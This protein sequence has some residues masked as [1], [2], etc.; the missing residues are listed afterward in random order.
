MQ[1]N[2]IAIV[3]TTGVGKSNLAIELAKRFNGEV[4]NADTLQVYK[5]LDI[6]TNKVTEAEKCSIPHHLMDFLDPSEEYT[7]KDFI[8]QATE[9]I[10]QIQS[11]NRIPILVGGTH[12]YVQSLLWHQS[13]ISEDT[14]EADNIKN[15]VPHS[16]ISEELAN[17]IITLLDKSDPAKFSF[18]N[19]EEKIVLSKEM[20]KIL[21]IVDPV[22][23]QKWHPHND[24]KIRRSLEI[25]L[26][27]G[28]QHSQL[29]CEQQEI[30]IPHNGLRYKT[31]IFWLY[32][33]PEVLQARLDQRVEKMLL[34]G[35]VKELVE[36][37]Q[38]CN[39]GLVVGA[40]TNSSVL[41]VSLDYT[42]GILQ[43][44]GF[45]E[46]DE[47]LLRYSAAP[48][49]KEEKELFNKSVEEMKLVTRQYARKQVK[50]IRNRL[51]KKCV[52]SNEEFLKS[53]STLNP[54][55]KCGADEENKKLNGLIA[56]GKVVH[57][58]LLDATV[59][60]SEKPLPEP[61]EVNELYKELTKNTVK[62]QQWVKRTCSICLTRNSKSQLKKNLPVSNREFY[63]DLEWEIHLKSSQHRKN[64]K[65][66]R[67]QNIDNSKLEK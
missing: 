13:I 11:R 39:R 67:D 37:R 42:R 12:Y 30:E 38:Q 55:N 59:F 14:A 44:I 5:G 3:G 20:H 63:G 61:E 32:A 22:M 8:S 49:S 53:N 58:F 50:W 47:Y 1:K 25:F 48:S 46:F 62:S 18:Y 41:P 36:M 2:L 31:L 6:A 10:E 26:S 45:K 23:S 51:V 66:H 7:V 57:L 54:E 19:S 27:S 43:A 4:I 29:I 17:K 56:P 65:Y 40:T 24:R 16:S 64:I 35:L 34:N 9:V 52:E 21:E 60:L 33:E 15:L 28:K